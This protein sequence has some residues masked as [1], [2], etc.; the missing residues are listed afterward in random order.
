[1]YRIRCA[2]DCYNQCI[3]GHCGPPISVGSKSV[4]MIG[5]HCNIES[6]AYRGAISDT[7]V[8]TLFDA[9]SISATGSTSAILVA[10]R[11]EFLTK[12]LI[13]GNRCHMLV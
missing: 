1:M 3:V 8:V 4:H 13:Q 9:K 2:S 5:L 12:R 6:T 10:A 7:F 11:I